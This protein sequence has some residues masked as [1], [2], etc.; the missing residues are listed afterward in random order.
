MDELLR[1]EE[2]R[3]LLEG[4]EAAERRVELARAKLADI[5]RQEVAARLAS[6]EVR[7]LE[8]RRDEVCDSDTTARLDTA[9]CNLFDVLRA[10]LDGR[11]PLPLMG[12]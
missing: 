6:E 11:C 5:E 7:R 4:V 2:N 1:R 10:R 12:E 3:A 9:T 8:R